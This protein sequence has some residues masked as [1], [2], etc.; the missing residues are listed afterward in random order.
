MDQLEANK[1]WSALG[2]QPQNFPYYYGAGANAFDEEAIAGAEITIPFSLDNFPHMIEGIRV[3]NTWQIPDEPTADELALATFVKRYVD[4]EQSLRIE[5]TQQSIIAKAIA[6]PLVQGADGYVYHAF[7]KPFPMA[8]G[9]TINVVIRR[10]TSYP[11][12]GETRI[13]PRVDVAIVCT[14]LR[15]DRMTM[16]PL[17]VKNGE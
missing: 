1:Y 3:R 6:Q 15:A 17:R 7:P 14:M 8:G 5:L 12:L 13:N 2:Y 10:L 11:I 9:N 16:P 4:D